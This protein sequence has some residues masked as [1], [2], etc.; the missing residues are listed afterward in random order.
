MLKY[1]RSIKR[2]LT[3]LGPTGEVQEA[4]KQAQATRLLLEKAR[5]QAQE[6]R[7]L[8]EKSREGALSNKDKLIATRKI[9]QNAA[10]FPNVLKHLN[11][12]SENAE[13]FQSDVFL[14]VTAEA[15]PYAFAASKGAK[16][17][18]ICD[19]TEIPRLDVR[20]LKPDWSEP[21]MRMMNNA[22]SGYLKD[23]DS[24]LSVG[25]ELS[26]HLEEFEKPITVF[27]NYRYA[28]EY[29][30]SDTLR[31][32]LNISSDTKIVMAMSTIASEFDVILNAMSQVENSHLVI[33]GKLVPLQYEEEMK[34]LAEDLGLSD[35][36][37]ILD[38]VP[39]SELTATLSSVDVGLI[40]RDPSIPNN[41]VSL[42]NRIFDYMFAGVPVVTPNIPDIAK[43]VLTEKMGSVV[44]ERTPE[45]WAHSIQEALENQADMRE[46]AL[47][48]SKKMTWETQEDDIYEALGRPASITLFGQKNL[49]KHNRS[50]RIAKTLTNRNVKVKIAVHMSFVEAFQ[51]EHGDVHGFEL[52]G[53]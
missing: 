43:I 52:V 11:T 24:F 5:E 48:A 26:K 13:A 7:Q 45:A 4:K 53:Y 42:P 29:V 14:P 22:I 8:L 33:L 37:D 18:I 36:F 49:L 16:M 9:V 20:T 19:C 32:R 30:S 23:V 41:H 10:P 3:H 31:E 17:P 35:R 50:M 21:N 2:K 15:V 6:T 44:Y 40:V 34:Q 25:W 1:I 27:P 12:I 38:Q 51:E 39:Y 47:T 28:E 46:N